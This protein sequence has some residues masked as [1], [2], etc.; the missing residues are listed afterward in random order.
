MTHES[1]LKSPLQSRATQQNKSKTGS[2]HKTLASSPPSY[3]PLWT[4]ERFELKLREQLQL[5]IAKNKPQPRPCQEL[6]CNAPSVKTAMG[7]MPGVVVNEGACRAAFNTIASPIQDRGSALSV[8]AV[9][10]FHGRS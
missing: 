3:N 8:G 7:R 4:N 2:K 10:P 6:L 5:K 9:L 1:L